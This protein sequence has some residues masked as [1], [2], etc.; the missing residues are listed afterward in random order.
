MNK[1]VTCF[2]NS[3]DVS[4]IEAEQRQIKLKPISLWDNNLLCKT[5]LQ[6]INKV[7]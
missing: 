6:G 3:Y 7:L 4:V 1:T 2:Y 5:K